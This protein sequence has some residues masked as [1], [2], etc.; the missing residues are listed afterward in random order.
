MKKVQSKCGFTTKTDTLTLYDT[1]KVDAVKF[2][3][4]F[5]LKVADTIFLEKEKI[6]IKLIRLKPDS[7]KI[8]VKRDTIIK[9]I[10]KKVPV[11][12]TNYNP[13]FWDSNKWWMLMLL[14][15]LFTVCVIKK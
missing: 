12:T 3:T 7:F 8:E 6:K 14:I 11:N 1:I 4:L 2:D 10:I 5:K 9:V 15:A 13:N